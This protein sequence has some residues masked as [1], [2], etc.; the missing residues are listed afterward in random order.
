MT[1]AQRA[2]HE[3]EIVA[4]P[5]PGPGIVARF[6]HV[7]LVAIATGEQTLGLQ[8]LLD[9]C[10]AAGDGRRLVRQLAGWLSLAEPDGVPSFALAVPSQQGLAVLLHGDADA[11]ITSIGATTRL[12]GSES[13]AWVDR[14]IAW[15]V[16]EVA[17]SCGQQEEAP[18][19]PWLNLRAGVVRG[20]GL[21][22]RWARSGAPA[23][24]S[25]GAVEA[26]VDSSVQPAPAEPRP[27]PEFES[28]LLMDVGADITAV[29]GADAG[30]TPARAPIEAQD[31]EPHDPARVLVKGIICK[32]GH[33]NDPGAAFCGV[34]G[35]SMVQQTHQLVDGVR[36]PLGVLVLDDGS[37][38]SVDDH[39]VI[40]R[41]PEGDPR[42]HGAEARPLVLTDVE[43][44]VSRTHALLSI[45]GWDV[46]LTDLG[47]SN[48]TYITAPNA[49]S[50]TALPRH[51][52]VKIS[53]GTRIVMG[54]RTLVFDAHNQI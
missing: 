2:P 4:R 32:R 22:A 19:D 52:A 12:F 47:S 23:D 6:G 41:E 31:E 18:L 9:E 54:S 17:L 8:H 20:G 33:F 30:A 26:T 21:V 38:F 35:I 11:A 3:D 27:V 29:N 13:A 34:C 37:T 10:S 39:Y 5:V 28:V 51:Q 25:P 14:L 1:H 24:E 49:S 40:G 45:V 50:S 15:P 36:P 16:E 7:L 44:T 42:V 46:Q 48:G 43:G 53:P